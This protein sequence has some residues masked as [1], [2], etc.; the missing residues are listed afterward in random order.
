M[1]ILAI[2]QFFQK[3]LTKGTEPSAVLVLIPLLLINFYSYA[4]HSYVLHLHVYL[5]HERH[6]I[7]SDKLHKLDDADAHLLFLVP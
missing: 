1:M 4:L 7:P 3:R 6:Q 5:I 2:E